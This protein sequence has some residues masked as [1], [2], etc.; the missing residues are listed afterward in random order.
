MGDT[1]GSS[2][3]LLMS[4]HELTGILNWHDLEEL[5]CS[6]SYKNEYELAGGLSLARSNIIDFFWD[7]LN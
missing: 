7:Q 1:L 4:N 6:N 5:E 3:L 2:R